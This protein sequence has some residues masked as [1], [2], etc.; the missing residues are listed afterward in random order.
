[1]AKILVVGS[2][3]MDVVIRVPHIPTEGETIMASSVIYYGG[4]KGANQAITVGRLG[5]EV[6]MIGRIGADDYGKILYDNLVESGIHMQGVEYD[7]DTPTGTAYI[8]V[9]DSGENNIVVYPGAN[10]RL[11]PKQI[12]TYENLFDKADYCLIQMEIPLE[13][14]E[15]IVRVCKTKGV[16]I[17]LN[18][19][20]AQTLQ[21]T[22]LQGV[23]MII[24]NESELHLLCPGPYTVEEKARNLYDLGVQNV[25]VTLGSKGCMLVN[26][27]GI[28]HFA[29]IPVKSVDT[30]AAGDSFI[31]GLAVALSE[32]KEVEEAIRFAALVAGIAV[33]REGAQSSIPDRKTVEA[34]LIE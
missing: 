15:H 21:S 2:I 16:K 10:S 13:T 28:Q 23:H 22:L 32:N 20:P 24:P 30:T 3:N 31:G 19:A 7:A 14:I 9:S 25:V 1:L 34:Y 29:A 5:G 4:G 33:S 27:E 11:D 6:S 26:G 18:P 12:Q 8:N 17:L